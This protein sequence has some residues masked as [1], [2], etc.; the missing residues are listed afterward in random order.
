MKCKNCGKHFNT[1]AFGETYC[2]YCGVSVDKTEKQKIQKREYVER[3]YGLLI[4]LLSIFI[5]IPLLI[6]LI[7]I[8]I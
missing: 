4:L 7:S 5:G 2:P 3:R 1:S 6:F 8:F